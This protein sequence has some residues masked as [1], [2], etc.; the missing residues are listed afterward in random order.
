M[1]SF[2][3][4]IQHDEKDIRALNGLANVYEDQGN[5]E[6]ALKCLKRCNHIKNNKSEETHVRLGQ[7]Y[8]KMGKIDKALN[9]FR[10]C[11]QL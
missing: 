4:C 2:T 3:K 11:I 10:W 5:F 9:E 1:S 6:D 7:V 8:D